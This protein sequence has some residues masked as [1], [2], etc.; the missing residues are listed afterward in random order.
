MELS[1]IAED[2]KLI[3]ESDTLEKLNKEIILENQTKLLLFY[4]IYI[5]KIKKIIYQFFR[6]LKF[7]QRFHLF[8]IIYI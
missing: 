4:N 1:S 3:R 5:A 7:Y 2:E 6:I 8:H